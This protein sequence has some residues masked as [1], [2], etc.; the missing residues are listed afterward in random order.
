[1]CLSKRVA[2]RFLK[3][4]KAFK[5]NTEKAS[6]ARPKNAFIYELKA[7]AAV[8]ER[9]SISNTRVGSNEANFRN[10]RAFLS[11]TVGCRG[12]FTYT[13]YLCIYKCL[14]VR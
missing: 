6:L 3:S 14:V 7:H 12:D 8:E 4:L 1:M 2:L 10:A 11:S 9:W 5:V 13:F